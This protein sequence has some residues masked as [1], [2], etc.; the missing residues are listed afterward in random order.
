MIEREQ[1]LENAAR[2]IARHRHRFLFGVDKEVPPTRD[3][4][5]CAAAV[6]EAILG[7]DAD[8]LMPEATPVR[9]HPR[10]WREAAT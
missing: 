7:T 2:A 4:R 9:P 8:R 5:R 3:D 6:V 1:A 10:A